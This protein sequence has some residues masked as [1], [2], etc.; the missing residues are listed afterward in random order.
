[1]TKQKSK[2]RQIAC[3]LILVY[4]FLSG[5][6]IVGS[7]SHAVEHQHGT[8]HAEQHASF[9]C[10]W[11]CAA[12]SFIHTDHPRPHSSLNP[13]F[14]NLPTYTQ[15]TENNLSIFSFYARPPPTSLS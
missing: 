7:A 6:M 14:H 8:N 11:M 15:Q 12:S 9:V 1:M 10:T 2:T 4:L 5:F 3:L 13:V